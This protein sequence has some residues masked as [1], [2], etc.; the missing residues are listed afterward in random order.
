MQLIKIL[1]KIVENP[2]SSQNYHE[3]KEYFNQN[4]QQQFADAVAH[5]LQV[6]YAPN[7]SDTPKQ[8]GQPESSVNN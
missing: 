7:H 4:N 1:Y 8:D 6:K 5:L 2:K 3:L